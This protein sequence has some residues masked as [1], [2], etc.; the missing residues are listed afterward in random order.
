MRS[1]DKRWEFV[2]ARPYPVLAAVTLI[3]LGIHVLLRR[4]EDWHKV[5]L[6]SG[7]LLLEGQPIYV[8][9]FDFSYPPAAAL[10]A[11]AFTPIPEIARPLAWCLLNASA[12][13]VFWVCSWRAAGGPRLRAAATA[14]D[15]NEH[16][17]LWIGMA[18]AFRFAVSV[19]E[20]QQ[21]DIFI[22]AT[23]AAA[24][25]AV[26]NGRWIS[27]A[28]ICAVGAAIKATPIGWAGYFLLRRR[29]VAAV[30]IVAV[31]L[32]LSIL[33]DLVSTAPGGGTWLGAWVRT[34]LEPLAT[35]SLPLGSARTDLIN[36]Q[37][38]PGTLYRL[39]GGSAATNWMILLA[40]GALLLVGV[41][42]IARTGREGWGLAVPRE[43][44]ETSVVILSM[45][46][47]SP[48]SSKPHFVVLL[49]PAYC[50]ARLATTER[51]RLAGFFVAL[52][53]ASSVL[54]H[55][56]IVGETIGRAVQ[57]AGGITACGLALWLGCVA[58]LF[59]P[60]TMQ[61]AATPPYETR[62]AVTL[63]RSSPPSGC[64]GSE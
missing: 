2:R 36:N 28:A 24:A 26:V 41:L 12:L 6:P 25:L 47:L 52:A 5:Y 29:L 11:A 35:G 63:P 51:D 13:I 32:A 55:Q 54:S 59:R 42:A 18:I 53:L 64:A 16:V 38:V 37:S 45:V 44:V 10:L 23:T 8:P 46:L 30:V 62:G 9:P 33:P 43:G 15:M 27:A 1:Q 48:S 60:V 56:S 57:W 39:L 50:V 4:P 34:F 14:A 19:L 17:A 31:T 49:L 3:V 61:R 7:R 20:H 22:A 21:T 58:A 40:N